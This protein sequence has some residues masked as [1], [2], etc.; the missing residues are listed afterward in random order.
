[1]EME[2]MRVVASSSNSLGLTV[3]SG[4]GYGMLQQRPIWQ[5]P[6]VQLDLLPMRS[7]HSSETNTLA[8]P[9]SSVTNNPFSSWQMLASRT[10]SARSGASHEC[11]GCLERRQLSRSRLKMF[12]FFL[13][14]PL[15]VGLR[16]LGCCFLHWNCCCSMCVLDHFVLQVTM[17]EKWRPSLLA[18]MV[19]VL[20]LL[21]FRLPEEI[22]I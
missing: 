12:F 9:A 5:S 19:L 3:E 8:A 1:M 11:R 6:P 18:A 22:S 20:L 17:T 14:I 10:N 4:G 15:L 2:R 13:R 21:G 16:T 7:S